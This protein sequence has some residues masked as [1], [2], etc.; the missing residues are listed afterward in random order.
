MNTKLKI[1]MIFSRFQAWLV[2][3]ADLTPQ[4]A[5][6]EVRFIRSTFPEAN[7]APWLFARTKAYWF[8]DRTGMSFPTTRR[9]R[10]DFMDLLFNA[11]D[12]LSTE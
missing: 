12:S 1:E 8:A 7:A 2:E 3:H 10:R 6:E 9:Q 11:G 5:A 4:Q